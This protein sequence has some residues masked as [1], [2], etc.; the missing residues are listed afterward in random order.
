MVTG[1][2]TLDEAA[3][4]TSS[5]A[6]FLEHRQP[7]LGRKQRRFAGIDPNRQ[8]QFV[9]KPDGVANH[10]EM[11]VGDRVERPRV[12]GNSR[13]ILGLTR[14]FAPC[15]AAPGPYRCCP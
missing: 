3:I 9:G 11:A 4:D 2:K 1:E 14:R 5:I 12:K 8:H 13:H 15:K 10:V 6:N 7:V